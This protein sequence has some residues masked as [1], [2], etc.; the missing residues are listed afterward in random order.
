MQVA[1]AVV[2]LMLLRLVLLLMV[3][4]LV[5]KPQMELTGLLIQAAAVVAVVMLRPLAVMAVQEL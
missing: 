5:V 2:V 3:V 4:V 1:V